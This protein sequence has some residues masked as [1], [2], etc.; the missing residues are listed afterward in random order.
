MSS[1]YF[2][3]SVS[4]L[5]AEEF[6]VADVAVDDARHLADQR[7]GKRINVRHHDDGD[8]EAGV[9]DA[10]DRKAFGFDGR[11]DHDGDFRQVALL[12]STTSRRQRKALI[13]SGVAAT[14]S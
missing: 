1:S 13:V 3:A 9:F 6:G 5:A 8:A 11:D 4:D 12:K 7:V 10:G 2:W 14:L